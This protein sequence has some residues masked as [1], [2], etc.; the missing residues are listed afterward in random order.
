MAALVEGKHAGSEF[1]R[2]VDVVRHHQHGEATALPEIG[3]QIMHV[4][5]DARIERAER[6]VEPQHERVLH[7]R[8][9]DGKALLHPARKLASSP[10]RGRPSARRTSPRSAAG[11]AF[12]SL[13]G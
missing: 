13:A 6:L 1:E 9:G 10:S 3:N 11:G 7:E 12:R 2:F 8:L 4:E 5:S